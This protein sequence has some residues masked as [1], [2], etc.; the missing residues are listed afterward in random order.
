[1]VLVRLK[2]GCKHIAK[3]GFVYR[4]GQQFR[5]TEEALAAFGDKF[6][7]LPEPV[8]EEES[9]AGDEL[10]PEIIIEEVTVEPKRKRKAK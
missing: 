6:E 3:G 10:A 2:Q 5:V 9:G 4:G 7:V 1:M 8:A